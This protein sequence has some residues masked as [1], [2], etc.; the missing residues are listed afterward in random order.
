MGTINYGTS[1]YITIGYNCNNIDYEEEFYNDYIQDDYEN[2][3]YFLGKYNFYYFHVT[4]EPGYYEGFYIN[5]ENNFGVCY[6]SSE[7][8]KEALKEATQLKRFLL[9]CLGYNCCSVRPGWCMGYSNYKTSIEEIN[10]AISEIKEEIKTTPTY[11]QYY[12]KEAM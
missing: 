7:D 12:L 11:R 8:K 4:V 5:I 3:K 1:D 10:K 2:I 6:D 9:G